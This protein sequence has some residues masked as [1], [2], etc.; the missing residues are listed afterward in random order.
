MIAP[1]HDV[2]YPDG[3]QAELDAIAGKIKDGSLVVKSIY[4]K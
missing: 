1:Q 4:Q 2:M 3:V